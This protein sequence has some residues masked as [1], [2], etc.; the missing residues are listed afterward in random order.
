MP[1]IPTCPGMSAVGICNHLRLIDDC[2]IIKPDPISSICHRRGKSLCCF[3]HNPLFTRQ[4]RTGDQPDSRIF[5]KPPAP[6]ER[7]D[8]NKC[9]C[10]RRADAAQRLIGFTAI[11]R[12]YMQNEMPLHFQCTRNSISG[13][14]GTISMIWERIPFSAKF[15][16]MLRIGCWQIS[17]GL[18]SKYSSSRLVTSSCS[19]SRTYRYPA[20]PAPALEYL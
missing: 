20:A 1:R 8:P 4:H 16:R 9:P 18:G 14:V 10:G 2:H 6:A 13:R 19:S 17:P 5:R 3:S 11:C 15:F 7:T 12:S